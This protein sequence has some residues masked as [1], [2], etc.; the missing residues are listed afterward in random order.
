MVLIISMSGPD[1][2]RDETP[3]G[4]RYNIKNPEKPGC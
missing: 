3:S 2:A 1:A 4:R